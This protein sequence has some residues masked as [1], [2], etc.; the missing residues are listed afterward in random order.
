[1]LA[2]AV[3]MAEPTEGYWRPDHPV[4]QRIRRALEDMTGATLGA[5]VCGIDGC[6]VPNWAIPLAGLAHAFARLGSGAGLAAQ[7]AATATRIARPAGPTPISS[8]AP[9][10]RHGGHAAPAGPGAREERG[11]RR[12]LRRAPRARPRLRAQ[13]RRRRQARRRGRPGASHRALL[14]RRRAT[15]APAQRSPTGAASRSGRCAPRP[16]WPPCSPACHDGWPG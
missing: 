13:D 12:L 5:D 3:H 7:R 11:G 8:P 9:A 6:S 16:S 1:M 2:T 14:S 4:Q 10:P 15:S